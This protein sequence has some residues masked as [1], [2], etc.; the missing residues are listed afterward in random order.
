MKV[1]IWFGRGVWA[2]IVGGLVVLMAVTVSFAATPPNTVTFDNQSGERALVKL[3]GPSS[4]AAAVQN[5]KRATVHAAAGDYYIMVQYGNESEGYRFT[6]GDPFTVTQTRTQY[7]A[8]TITLHPVLAG[9]YET[10]P[11]SRE[12]FER[13]Q[14]A[15]GARGEAQGAKRGLAPATPVPVSVE[16]DETTTGLP[17]TGTGKDGAPMVLIPKGEF[18][19][20]TSKEEMA[21][22]FS[23]CQSHGFK[24]EKCEGWYED[25][26]PRH[27]VAL[28]AFYLDQYEVNNRRF[29]AFVKATGHR[30]NAE[31]DGWAV[32]HVYKNG[33]WQVEAVDGASWRKPDGA[34]AVLLS[35][36]EEHPVVQVSWVDAQA[37][38]QWAGKRLP[39]EAEFEYA[40][41]AGTETRYWW[42]DGNP[43]SRS[44]ANIADEAGKRQFTHWEGIMTGY[45][46]DGYA[47]TAPVGSYEANPWGLYDLTGNVW[48]WTAD[49]YDEHYYKRSLERNPKGPTHGKKRVLRGGSWG[50]DPVNVGAAGRGRSAPGNG[51]GSVGGFRCAKTP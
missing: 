16:E 2:I 21:K 24:R 33:Q 4:Q 11:I 14:V 37:Y 47:K 12:E 38:C 45:D 15:E 25:E 18:W 41:R 6:K 40:N 42:G 13:A 50:L 27:R 32:A 34:E 7:S 5:G 10:E 48:E 36:R 51:L 29:D 30:T 17:K 23:D 46:D 9:N 3:V 43:G 35:N 44:V 20:G 31:K 8:I 1:K 28:D 22:V 26:M 39:T 49:W 19:M